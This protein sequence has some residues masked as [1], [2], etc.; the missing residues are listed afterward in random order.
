MEREKQKSIMRN[1][2]KTIFLFLLVFLFGCN[3]KKSFKE[4]SLDRYRDKM[5]AAWIGQMAGVGW[6]LPTEF[7]YVD[8]IIPKEEVP[9][10]TPE[11]VNQQG[12]DDL[13][14][15][16]TFLSSM[17]QYGTGVSYRLAGID[18]ANTGYGLWAANRAGRENLRSGIAPPE[19]GHPHY[20][21]HCEDIDYQIEADYSGI[22]APGMPNIPIRL[23]EKFG[24]MMNY[25]DG[26]YAG[27]FV[28][29]M[30]SAAY[31]TDD[32]HEIIHE[33]LKCIPEQ[34]NYAACVRDVI[35]WHREYPDQWEKCWEQIMDKYFRTLEHQPFHRQNSEAWVGIDAKINGAFIVL[36]LLYGNGDMDSTIVLSMR[37]GLDSDCN[38]SNAAG[39]LATTMGFEN[40]PEKFKSGLDNERNFSY[41]E[42]NFNDLLEVSESFTCE[43]VLQEGGK[44]EK[45]EKGGEIF[46]IRSSR[47]V[48][49][50]FEPAYDSGEHD[51]SNRYDE[52][53]MSRILAYSH[54]DFVPLLE[55]VASGWNIYHAG[56]KSELRLVEYE[57][58]EDVLVL[59]PM[60]EKRGALLEYTREEEDDGGV[61]QTGS[62]SGSGVL[63]F[64]VNAEEGKPWNLSLRMNTPGGRILVEETIDHSTG[65]DWKKYEIPF[66]FEGGQV[67]RIR[68][69]IQ[70]GEDSGLNR[71]YIAGLSVE[72]DN[73]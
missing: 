28:G 64:C 42:Y 34:C 73:S 60:S 51:P 45:D 41:T 48:P 32:I 62:G 14:V 71:A 11:M 38:P 53:E 1:M 43:F 5:K 4:I 67:P 8:R 22:I 66:D 54:R 63:S 9:E 52:M 37:C 33:G 17:E 47:P 70:P 27:Q 6:G 46:H 36:G 30:Y 50:L 35:G 19:S 57:D 56:K 12:N 65:Q 44:I 24:R 16:M 23:G 29:G 7:D 18:F 20:N 39:I 13:Y 68:L 25:G 61:D 69:N 55:T 26:M 2:K 40:L 3:G 58:M 59:S 21:S 10:W 49:S 72:L 15:E 31:F